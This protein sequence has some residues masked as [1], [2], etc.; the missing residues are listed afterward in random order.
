MIDDDVCN[1][2][3]V[4]DFGDMTDTKRLLLLLLLEDQDRFATGC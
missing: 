3:D 2:D 1:D 4:C